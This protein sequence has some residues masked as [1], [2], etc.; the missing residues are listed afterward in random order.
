VHDLRLVLVLRYYLDLSFEEV[1][2]TLGISQKAAMSRVYRDG[3]LTRC[4]RSRW[5]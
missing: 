5:R 1:G 4:Q 2:Q 3:D